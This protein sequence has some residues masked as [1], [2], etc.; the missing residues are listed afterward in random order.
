MILRVKNKETLIIDSFIFKCSIGRKGINK[1]K[2]EGDGSSPQGTFSFGEIYWRSDRVKKPE[3]KLNCKSIKKEMGWC[4][5]PKSKF[6]NKQIS[7]NYSF[8][9][10]KLY[11]KDYKYN[12]LIV[13][14]YNTKKIIKNKGSAIFLHLTKDYKSTSGCIAVS[15]KDFLI[16]AKLLHKNSKIVI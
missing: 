6:Y 1:R 16:I 4:N 10:E 11:R 3:T 2:R 8:K 12:Y 7:T 5:D 15:E 14:N 13:I 9:S